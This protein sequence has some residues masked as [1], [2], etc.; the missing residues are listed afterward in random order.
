ME[1]VTGQL[2]P[3]NDFIPENRMLT[4]SNGTY[5]MLPD[6]TYTNNIIYS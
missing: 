2:I 6:M 4:F 5:Y 1:L 3:T